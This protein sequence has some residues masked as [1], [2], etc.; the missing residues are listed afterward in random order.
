MFQPFSGLTYD[1]DSIIAYQVGRIVHAMKMGWIKPKPPRDAD[2]E[3][4][5]MFYSLWQQDDQS[6]FTRR[7]RDHIPAPKMALPTHSESYNP[8][9]EYLLTEEEVLIKYINFKKAWLGCSG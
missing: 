1:F 9:P 8:P 6:D 3:A 4:A 7:Y 5:D 2:Q